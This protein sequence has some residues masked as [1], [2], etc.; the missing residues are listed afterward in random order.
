VRTSAQMLEGLTLDGGWRVLSRIVPL[1]SATGGTFSEGY[2][3]RGPNNEQAFLKALDYSGALKSPDPARALQALTETYNFER[4]LLHRCR[5]HGMDRIVVAIDDGTIR[6][7]GA[8]DGGVVQYL[9]FE[10]ADGDVRSQADTSQRFERAFSLRALHHVATGMVQLHS[11]GIAHQDVKPSNVLVFRKKE[12]KIAD[13]GRAVRNGAA[14][15]HSTQIVAGDPVYA[16]P[17]LLYREVDPD[18]N[19]RRLGCDAY[20]LGSMVVFFF[21]GQGM[22]ALL[23]RDLHPSHGWLAWG[24]TYRDVLPHVRDAFGRVVNNLK[25]ILHPD[26]RDRIVSIVRELCEPDPRLR[27]HPKDRNTPALQYSLRRYIAR[28]DWLARRAEGGL[29]RRLG[30]S[31]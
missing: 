31:P 14:P 10:L 22:T 12:S 20:L 24:G 30:A 17:E 18:W 25:L 29:N 28:F 2:L 21:T 19:R 5:A 3:V 16:P 13:L 4:D 15:P 7:N 1:S 11:D 6:I 9:V 23:A 27:G 26:D 8:P